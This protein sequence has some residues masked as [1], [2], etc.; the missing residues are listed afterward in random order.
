MKSW[1]NASLSSAAAIR[2]GKKS[3]VKKRLMEPKGKAERSLNLDRENLP[4]HFFV[5]DDPTDH[6]ELHAIEK[7]KS[8]APPANADE[9]CYDILKFYE[10][11]SA[12]ASAVLSQRAGATFPFPG[13]GRR[14]RD[15]CP[16]GDEL[17]AGCWAGVAPERPHVACIGLFNHYL[18][19]WREAIASGMPRLPRGPPSSAS[20]SSRRR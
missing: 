3:F 18:S 2:R 13:D 15:H 11:S 19:Y 16:A 4:R 10:F 12:V 14:I 1:P 17:G 20:A 9:S 8:L 6:K 5:D 7:L